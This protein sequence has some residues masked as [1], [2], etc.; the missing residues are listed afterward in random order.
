M[1]LLKPPIL[2]VPSLGTELVH[3]RIK[4]LEILVGELLLQSNDYLLEY[5]LILLTV[6][7]DQWRGLLP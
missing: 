1:L 5:P 3:E 2:S 6:R 7:E 4:L